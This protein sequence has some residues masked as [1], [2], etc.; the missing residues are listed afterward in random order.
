MKLK[1]VIMTAL[2]VSLL[3]A[4]CSKDND[5][6]SDNDVSIST[7]SA[8]DENSS[9]TRTTLDGY[10][11]TW[12]QGDELG[13]VK[14]TDAA[15]N[16]KFVLTDGAN[17]MYGKFA[18]ETETD[19]LNAGTWVAYYPYSATKYTSAK[20]FRIVSQPQ[21]DDTPNH[22][23][24]YD[25]LISRPVTISENNQ[26]LRFRMKHVFALVE[27]NVKLKEEA[28]DYVELA[29]CVLGTTDG[30]KIFAQN[31]YFD[32]QGS[33][34]FD[35]ISQNVAVT[36]S[37]YIEFTTANTSLWLLTRQS[38]LKPLTVTVF[39]TYG[40]ISSASAT[41]MPKSILEPGK[42]YVINLELDIDEVNPNSSTLTILSRS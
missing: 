8:S 18:A 7:I 4:G 21:M 5:P 16:H 26:D 22:V 36:R 29:Q 14:T 11:V 38:E 20:K 39:F 30:D 34:Q 12:A 10:R 25:W 19:N 37:P 1:Y 33:L 6:K 23:S 13:C 31:V 3:G 32:G 15:S 41:F 40:I 35:Y 24:T 9:D 17:T 28:Q 2:C 27:F 42:K